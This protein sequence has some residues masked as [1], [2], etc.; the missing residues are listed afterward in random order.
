MTKE[1]KKEKKEIRKE[2]KKRARALAEHLH[3]RDDEVMWDDDDYIDEF[4]VFRGRNLPVEVNTIETAIRNEQEMMDDPD[5]LWE[6][7][8][9]KH[10]GCYRYLGDSGYM[11]KWL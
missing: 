3:I 6:F 11:F 5:D 1:D 9:S 2:R 4:S 7:V 8:D 10:I